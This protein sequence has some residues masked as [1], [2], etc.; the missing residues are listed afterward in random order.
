MLLLAR[1]LFQIEY[2]APILVGDQMLAKNICAAPGGNQHGGEAFDVN[3]RVESFHPLGLS[4]PCRDFEGD[5]QASMPL[6]PFGD[7][8]SLHYDRIPEHVVPTLAIGVAERLQHF[9]H[10][11]FDFVGSIG[12]YLLG[13]GFAGMVCFIQACDLFGVQ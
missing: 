3:I 6:G 8:I 13:G 9:F 4:D 7:R 11:D 12:R 1:K 10:C 2:A 5:F